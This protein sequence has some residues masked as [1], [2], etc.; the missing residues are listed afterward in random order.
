MKLAAAL[1]VAALPALAHAQ[2][3][4]VWS[5]SV[6]KAPDDVAYLSYALPESDDFGI[7]LSCRVKSGQVKVMI[8]SDQRLAERQRGT[9]WLDR[10]GRP[11]PWPVSVT[12]AS[13]AASTTVRGL[14]SPDEM[15]GGSTVTAE[16]SNRAPVIAAFAKTGALR[17]AAL[18]A[19]VE[20][21]P[22]PRSQVSKFLRAC[23]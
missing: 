11:A 23:K 21:P 8:L 19:N 15:N 17:V 7:S 10:V 5:V 1:L 16:L 6:P 13:G 22:A 20:E 2:D 4:R 12:L 3:T 14:A 9:T 18:G